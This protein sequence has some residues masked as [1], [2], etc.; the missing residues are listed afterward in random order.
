MNFLKRRTNMFTPLNVQNNTSQFSD[1]MQYAYRRN[2][3][4]RFYLFK[5]STIPTKASNIPNSQPLS[6]LCFTTP[7]KRNHLFSL[8]RAISC[9]LNFLLAVQSSRIFPRVIFFYY[10]D[11]E[12]IPRL[13]P[14]A[15]SGVLQTQSS[16]PQPFR[17][18]SL[19]ITPESHSG[20]SQHL[21]FQP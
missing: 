5:F 14:I 11:L 20:I 19:S 3:A 9:I 4:V 7:S 1:Q 16:V 13:Y 17:R 12:S 2:F 15:A 8:A 21:S 6:A 18:P 10:L